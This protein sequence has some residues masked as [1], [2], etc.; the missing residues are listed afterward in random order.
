MDYEALL[1]SFETLWKHGYKTIF[2]NLYHAQFLDKIINTT[3]Y[4]P[5]AEII[6]ASITSKLGTLE[7]FEIVYIED[8]KDEKKAIFIPTYA[9]NDAKRVAESFGEDT[10]GL[11]HVTILGEPP[12]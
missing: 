7:N 12:K 10:Y 2:V 8:L 6:F 1:A 11:L 4:K 9:V 5:E 3:E